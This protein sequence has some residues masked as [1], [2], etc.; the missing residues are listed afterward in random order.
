MT[1][2][3]YITYLRSL[4]IIVTSQENKIAVEDP[5]DALTSEIIE[6]LK[7]RKTDI[8][9]FFNLIKSKKE[10]FIGIS[11]A[12]ESA[13]YPLSSAQKRMYFLYEFD[14][15]STA[16][17]VPVFFRIGRPLDI[18]RLETAFAKLVSRHQSLRTVFEIVDGVPV[19]RILNDNF[20]KME[21]YSGNVSEIDDC[22]NTF[23][24]PFNLSAEF[25]I[26]ISLMEVAGEDYLLMLDMHHIVND[27]VSHD[28]LMREF[29]ALYKGLQLDELRIQYTDY[30]VWQQSD[31]HQSLVLAH[32]SYWLDLYSKE[33][34]ALDLPLDYPR[35]LYKGGQGNSHSLHLNKQQS[36]RLR[37]LAASS[38]VTVYTLFLAVYNVL[39]SK[40]CNQ[41]DI[42]VGTPT[43]GRHHADLE[44]IVGM[45]V[46]TLALR[47]NVDSGISFKDFLASVH[48]STLSA[49]DHQLYQYEEL[50]DALELPRDASRSPLFDVFFSY[51]NQVDDSGFNDPELKISYHEVSY[52]IAKFDLSLAVLD[53][54]EIILNF[55]YRTDLFTA[56]S[57][58]RFSSYLHR[59]IEEV[60]ENENQLIRDITILSEAEKSQLLVDFN[61]T[62]ADYDLKQTV[63]DMFI[64]QC[65][66]TPDSDAVVFGEERLSYRDL[67]ERSDLWASHLIDSDVAAGSIVGL[68]MT[69]SSEM[70]TAI[71]AVMKAGAAYVPINPI[72][73]VSRT[74]HMLEECGSVFVISNLEKQP[75]ELL[76][77]T[78][79]S[80]KDLDSEQIIRSL[81][82]KKL[83]KVNSQSLAYV[84]YTSGSTG[85]P[86]GVMVHHESVT[87]LINYEREFFSIESSD[88]IL[89]FSPYYF[90]PSVEQIWLSLTTGAALV[91]V[92]EATLLESSILNSYLIEKGITHFHST[93]SF[94][95]KV[96]FEGVSTLRRVIS[97][98]EICKLQLA[99]KISNKYSF[100]NKYG[101]TETTVTFT[102]HKIV[103][104]NIQSKVS[105]GRPVANA[106]AYILD[107]QMNLLPI[108][109]KGE[110][111]IGGKGLSKGYLNRL[112]LT[113][114]RFVE[115]P[116]G[117]GLL[118][119]TGD[120]ARWFADGT[121][122]YLGRNDNQIKLRGYRIELGE[123][124]SQLEAIDT[125]N[126]VLVI[127]HGSDDNKQLIAYLSG[128]EQLESAK[129]KSILSSK[130][131]DYMIPS[132]F[133]WLDSFP[134]TANG[135]VDKRTLPNP[136]FTAGEVYV[137]A[138][139]EDQEKLVMI[140][141]DV[142]G[143]VA[144]KISIHSD[145]FNL[146]GHSLMAITLSNKINK[147]FSVNISLRDLFE[148]RTIS[149]LSIYILSA[150]KVSFISIPQAQ[151]E[152]YYPLSSAQK[153][154]YFLYEF[155]KESTAYN[156]P[157][158]FRI[159]RP[160]DVSRLE[161][162]FAKL[163]S[164]HQSL[165]TVFEIVDGIPVQRILNENSFKMG[166]YSGNVSE[167]D[168]YINAFIRPFNLSAE[169][170]IRISL[171]EVTGEDYLLMFD[172]HHIIN[173]GVSHEILMREFWALYKGLQLDAL[174]IQYTDYAVWQQSDS[175]QSL[176]STHKSYWLDLYSK[177]I[178]ALDLPLDY[179]R[180]LYKGG[181]GSSHSLHLDKEKTAKLRSLAASS[182]VTVYTLFLAVY[183]VLLSK[184]C[185]QDDIIVG[186]PTAG[187]HHADLE[188]IVGMFV[189]TLA[190]R[191]NVD[192]GI[193]FKDF[194]ASVHESTLSAF[195]HQLYQYEELVDALD[196]PRDASRSPLFDVLFTYNKQVDD[197]GFSDPELKISYH[198]VS[199][200]IAKFDLSLAILDAE[201]I[202]LDFGYR[203]DLFT[204]SSLARFS[205]YLHK[206]I[207][208][209]LE[210]ENQLISDI[211]IL[212]E[213]E[214]SQQLVEFNDTFADYDLQQTVLDMFISQ[215]AETP[216]SDAV[217]F[218]EERLSYRDLDERSDLWASHLIDSGVAAGSI[219]GLI[220]TRSSEMI[221]AILAVMKAEAA[222]VPINPTQ[223]VS[224]TAHMLEE[225]GCVFVISNLEK[226]S[227]ELD[228]YTYLSVENLDSEQIIRSLE[229][230]TLPKVNSQ[231]L[232]YV[233]YTSGSTG[234]PKGV[235]VEHES[236]TNLINHER[237]F[238]AIEAS[239][240]ILQ[241]SP[242]YFD[243][244]VE[245][246]WLSLTTGASLVLIDSVVL[247]DQDL[248]AAYLETHSVTHLNVTPSFLESLSLPALPNLKRIVVSGEECKLGLARR[249]NEDYDFYNEYG[250]TETTVISISQKL[251][252]EAL[253]GDKVSIGRPVANTQVYVLDAQMN[254]LPIGVK[255]ELYIGGK[256]LSKGYLNRL[257]L[258][259]E[260]FVENPFGTGLLYKT[261]DL[262]RWFSDGT[263]DY[264]G[265]NDNQIKLRGY[266]IELGEIES[267]L[268]AI[269]TV[270]QVLVIAHG[271]DDNKQLIAYLSGSEQLESAKI[272]SILSAKLPDYM[273]P[274]A[275]IWLDSFPVTANGKVDKRALPNPD[276]TAGE[277]YAAAENEDQE[278][279][280]MIWSDVLGIAADKISIHS[281][282]FNLG[283]HSLMAITLSNKINKVFSVNIS[284]RD[285]FEHRTIS[286][287]SIY[288]LSAE[289][290]G[291]VSIPQAQP[292]DYY[293][294]SSAQKRMYFLYEFDKE[295]T[296]YNMPGFFRIGRPLD[297]SRLETAF[298][299]LVSRHQSLRTVFEIVD[300]IPVQRILNENS[301]KM[302]HYSGDV[303]EMNTY[304]SAF[305]RPFNLSA[306]FP[307]RISLMEVAG[308]DYLLMFDMHH[309]INDGVSH[310]ILMREF[311]ALYK[312]LQLDEL[313][314]Q[315]TDYAVWQQS[316]SHQSL[317][318]AHKSYWLDLYSKEINALD[319][320]LDYPRPLYKGG[321]GSSHSLDLD[322]EKTTK[323]RSLAASSGV[324]VYTLFLAVY[325]VLLS[326]ICNQDDIIVG[327]PTAGR[328]HAD[329][330]GIVGMFVN[331]LALRNTVDSGISFKDFLASV[332]ESALSAF[333]HQLYQYEELV[334]ALELPRDA[335][336]NSLFDVSFT[337]Q[338]KVDDSSFN[339]PEFKISYHEVAYNTAKFDMSLAV[340]DAEEIGISFNYRTDLFTASSAARFSSY[341]HRIIEE[342]LENENQ[343]IS[344]I[345]ILSEAEKSQ[346]LVDF[347]DTFADYDLQQTVLDMFI[348]QCAETPDSDAVV[349]GEE[350]LSY[351]DLDTRSDLWASHLIDC[352]VTAGSIVG[353]IM[354]RSSEM[355]TAI[356]TVMKAGAA[357]VPINPTQPVS[358]TAHMLEECGCE[359][360]ISNLESDDLQGYTYL[361]VE[362]LD[363]EQIIR[364]L[365][366]KTLPKV[367]PQSLAYVIY[368]SG[369]TGNPKGVMVEHESVTN[370]INH[371]REFLAIE[372]SDKILQFSPY[373]FDVSVEQIWLSLTTGASLVL[374]DSVVLTDQDLFTAY[375]EVH[376]VT[377]LNVT[378]S[379]LESLSLPVLPSLKRIVV[380]GE[381]CKLGLARRYNIDYDFYNEYGPTETTVISISQKLTPK[382]LKGDKVS[383]GRPVANTQV[384]ILDAQMNLLPV[385][386]KGEL[387]IG[388][389]GLS[390]GYVNR[391]DLTQERFVKNPFGSGL[392]Y[393][394]GDL[395]RWLADGTI[396]Y[397]GRLDG[398]IKLN[399]V[400]I[401][402]G[403]IESHLKSFKGIKDVVVSLREIENNKTLVAYYV[404][405][406]MIIK[407]ELKDFLIDRLPFSMIPSHYMQLDKL[408]LSPTGKLDRR[409]LPDVEKKEKI[410]EAPSN[411]IETQLVLIW[412]E[413]LQIEIEK[414]NVN[415]GFF[416]LGGNSL[417]AIALV[418]TVSKML[419][420]KITLKE[421]FTKQSIREIANYIITIKQITDTTEENKEE[422][423]LIL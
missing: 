231:S 351:R 145:F 186:T 253:K 380:S 100:Y 225:C 201:E 153:R 260:R 236:V 203:T 193:S 216:D 1:T 325:N 87:N 359:F 148:H 180:P 353:L 173:D 265:R 365:E 115:N 422:I 244:S 111:Y 102:I 4:N 338:K 350:R 212:S 20:F 170:P 354:T 151:Q 189:N 84:I 30:A 398:Q 121:I 367:N 378:P 235:M 295:S 129:I 79:L 149:E 154:M 363:S 78:Y 266:R 123:I 414:I 71:L 113:Q 381:E 277:V 26:R 323:L 114:E 334:D 410:Y 94:L 293:P 73:P 45:F 210:N 40:V 81:E 370:L 175:H 54:E 389:K 70:I 409:L 261:G 126:Q 68:I 75:N 5:N 31:S 269:D 215:C 387:Y 150:E 91:L 191:N 335:S 423:K 62:F 89:Q 382:T 166:H 229:K 12:P 109:V 227:D 10:L 101:P 403:E 67:D 258:T 172:M 294:L 105:I 255:G 61:D 418:N 239:D 290:V 336:R 413:L 138:E 55:G 371:E 192:S 80:V 248:F 376:S 53:A 37:S 197:S 122:D 29:W 234:N 65:A 317:V 326:K 373:Y 357:Y 392:L 48:E 344:D 360:V 23:V 60:L 108:G 222:Y 309:I 276:F 39:L 21:H 356:L 240:K 406:E 174:R 220:M 187:R 119:K 303:S 275:Y 162:A 206:I 412:S 74:A 137:A 202:S 246:I 292:Q 2:D 233:I 321:Q 332:H 103:K 263:I 329:L 83:P 306:E 3:E 8:L 199:Y 341:L 14:K 358:R 257:D 322:K 97:G 28:I 238:L 13:Y 142:L 144:D 362:D 18:S 355:I 250:P 82:K 221:T 77:Y 247:T 397:L 313:R 270:N 340:L 386:V 25:P 374:I 179:P 19:Q 361:S 155:D 147:V 224:R 63:L 349:F 36:A 327:T 124:E 44:G 57:L 6:E 185:N 165:R 415:D 214:T 249:Y 158:F 72:Q 127:A 140:W 17:N 296:A 232:A 281:D 366:K 401:E 307:I 218:G 183:N 286:E 98:G 11:K 41:D 254:L 297:V 391:L 15:K 230:K 282:F 43:A 76:G 400:R 372:S 316:D 394:T 368:T 283:G 405:E 164:R 85:N 310:E 223:P 288:I 262:A 49:F 171:M 311:W 177:E 279:L 135:K 128:S 211:T 90:D 198:E 59:I 209:I 237:E 345:T 375:L 318:L 104:E 196:L 7:V 399:G 273:I 152:D 93:P 50:V 159:G 259:Q 47:N 125:V 24:R 298:A 178:N 417:K 169:F 396:D 302:G 352:G 58:A 421:I 112:D 337:Y 369:S 38:G 194:L 167:I 16:Y 160:L 217:V 130:L 208:E 243:V 161:T 34:S 271:S 267:Q 330:E 42:I 339:D 274:A 190:L 278:K 404:A 407:S 228:G 346:L 64:S 377:H 52:D 176:V 146:G 22:I 46:N 384:Y 200:N 320:P 379:F 134:V 120:L 383:I 312:G 342:I 182:G 347:N 272:K 96:D 264:L 195:D 364:S 348:S 32:K 291:F 299:K 33:I 157:G 333:D 163:V 9:E 408:P 390:K 86:K 419:S 88:R 184:L 188:G 319:L 402:L 116:F 343:L 168:G 289:K 385:G 242:Y 226:Q 35:P 110:L 252:P 118:Y 314:I 301:F 205:S 92:D 245:Q 66:E 287:L 133:I 51:Q 393:K 268:E 305:I 300:G 141:S 328:H 95:E 106:Q 219:V 411:E 395:A 99:E 181:Q 285:L 416:E 308:E 331:T 280:V 207:E 241:F 139:N 251:T 420:V 156:M 315:Y 56:L 204:A 143:I 117:T 136:D 27:G 304:I 131:P 107:G 69:R 284:L 256:G 213:A 132:A 388:G 324:T